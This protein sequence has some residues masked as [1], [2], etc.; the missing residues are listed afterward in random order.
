MGSFML[1]V[2][3]KFVVITAPSHAFALLLSDGNS[4]KNDVNNNGL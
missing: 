1:R 3:T 4:S 2:F